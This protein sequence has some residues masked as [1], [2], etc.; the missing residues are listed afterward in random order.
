MECEH[1][2][3]IGGVVASIGGFEPEEEGGF[4]ADSGAGLH[5]VEFDVVVHGYSAGRGFS[6]AVIVELYPAFVAPI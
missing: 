5:G 3:K 6:S 2:A 1:F 4:V